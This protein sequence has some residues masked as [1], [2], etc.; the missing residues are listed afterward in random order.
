MDS[1]A[2]WVKLIYNLFA[3]MFLVSITMWKSTLQKEQP[4]MKNSKTKICM[5]SSGKKIHKIVWRLH[6]IRMEKKNSVAGLWWSDKS[7]FHTHTHWITRNLFKRES[8]IS[9]PASHSH[10]ICN[11]IW[12]SMWGR[13]INISNDSD[14]LR[15][16]DVCNKKK[17]KQNQNTACLEEYLRHD[18]T[19]MSSQ[20]L[21]HWSICGTD[22][23]IL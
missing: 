8:L 22:K 20:L 13:D 2:V 19:L 4:D 18:T 1:V 9:V 16:W 7:T 17:S 12:E 14:R 5:H 21:Q 10:T 6:N 15:R 11:L 3:R 23:N